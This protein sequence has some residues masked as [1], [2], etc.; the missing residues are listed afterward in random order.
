VYDVSKLLPKSQFQQLC[1]LLPTPRQKRRGRKLINKE[2]LVAGILQILVNGVAWRKMAECGC[3]YASC[4]I[5]LNK[6]QRRGKLH[7]IFKTLAREKTDLTVGSIDTTFIISFAFRYMTGR[8]GKHKATGMKVSIFT[9]KT[10]LPADVLFNKG[11]VDDKTFLRTHIKNTAGIRKRI[12]NLDMGYMGITFRREMQ[13]KKI[14]VNMGVREQDYQRTRGPK[15]KFD[16][17]IYQTRLQ[18]ERTNGWVK[19]FRSLR[20][21]RSYHVANFKAL[22]YLALIIILVR[23]S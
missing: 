10:G 21:R 7:F 4:W 1:Q 17:Q 12:L 15:F 8:S 20:L 11:N 22:V 3:S 14:R 13:T 23:Q 2:A 5:Y 19:A 6:L 16:K 18:L 9:D